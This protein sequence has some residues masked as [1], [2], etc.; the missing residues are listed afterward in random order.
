[1]SILDFMAVL[2]TFVAAPLN[3]LVAVLLVRLSRAHPY[4][5]VLRERAIFA[6]AL[7]II[8]SVSAVIFLNNDFVPPPLNLE[9]TKWLARPTLLVLSIGPTLYWLRIYMRR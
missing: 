4:V 2:V 1:V 6:V 3:W 7:A 9:Q 8:V 5:A